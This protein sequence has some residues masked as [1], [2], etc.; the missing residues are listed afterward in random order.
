[1][2]NLVSPNIRKDENFNNYYVKINDSIIN[3]TVKMGFP[4]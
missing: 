4:N 2:N 3:D 1:M